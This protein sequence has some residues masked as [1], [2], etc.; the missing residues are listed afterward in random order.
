MCGKPCIQIFPS[1]AST[2]WTTV[3]DVGGINGRRSAWRPGSLFFR[4][5]QEIKQ[6][7]VHF[8]LIFAYGRGQGKKT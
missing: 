6:L 7:R 8:D 5:A 4:A 1:D 3:E 2:N